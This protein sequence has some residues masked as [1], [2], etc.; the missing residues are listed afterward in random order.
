MYFLS[1]HNVLSTIPGA[2][3]DSSSVLYEKLV[4]ENRLYYKKWFKK[5]N[6][7]S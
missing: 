1:P 2:K 3:E 7:L 5:W 4:G 6:A